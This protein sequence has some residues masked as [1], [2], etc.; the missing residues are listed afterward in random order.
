MSSQ[1]FAGRSC[2]EPLGQLV[3]SMDTFARVLRSAGALA[4]GIFRQYERRVKIERIRQALYSSPFRPFRLYLADG[5]S[6]PVLHE[7]FVAFEPAGRELIVYLPDNSYQ[8]VDVMLVT[9]LAVSARNGAR[10]RKKR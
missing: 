10:A 2:R 6:L 1:G 3:T 5:G 9:R 8:V 7:D 4:F